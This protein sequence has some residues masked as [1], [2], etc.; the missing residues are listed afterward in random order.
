MFCMKRH[1]FSLIARILHLNHVEVIGYSKNN[2]H[3]INPSNSINVIPWFSRTYHCKGLLSII[4]QT[5]NLNGFIQAFNVLD[6]IFN[7]T[8]PFKNSWSNLYWQN[9]CL[10]FMYQY[11]KLWEMKRMKSNM[12]KSWDKTIVFST[13]HM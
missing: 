5:K 6:W 7:K 13:Y 9:I 8:K 1:Q 12:V 4:I 10:I 3:W 2:R 11:L